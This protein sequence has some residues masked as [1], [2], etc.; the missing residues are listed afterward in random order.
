MMYGPD[1][2]SVVQSLLNQALHDFFAPIFISKKIPS[3]EDQREFLRTVS[4]I[5]NR[6]NDPRALSLDQIINIEGQEFTAKNLSES[7]SLLAIDEGLTSL[8]ERFN[9]RYGTRV[10]SRQLPTFFKQVD[11]D[12]I[13]DNTTTYHISKKLEGRGQAGL[14]NFYSD[15][16]HEVLIKEDDPDTCVL[17]GTASFVNQ[18]HLL[19]K[20]LEDC[21]NFASVGV[22]AKAQG[23]PMVVSIQD[24]VM[25]SDQSGRVRP[26]DEI[27]YG[28]KRNPNTLSSYESWYPDNIKQSIASLSPNVQWQLAASL[29]SC[30]IAGDESLHVGQFMAILDKDNNIT[31]IKRIDLGARERY[32]VARAQTGQHDPF[33]D[34]TQ[35]QA[36]G[37]WGKDYLTYLLADPSFRKIY[38]NLWMNLASQDETELKMKVKAAS[39]TAFLT[40]FANIPE[41]LREKT[42]QDV[43]A[44]FNKDAKSSNMALSGHTTED[45]ITSLA[46]QISDIDANRMIEMLTKV[47][48]EFALESQRDVQRFLV[49]TDPMLLKKLHEAS[50]LK[51]ALIYG[52]DKEARFEDVLEIIK[53]F[54]TNINELISS[55]SE[56]NKFRFQ[57]LQVL[58]ESSVDLL[59]A[60]YLQL[61]NQTHDKNQ[62]VE[63]LKALEEMIN[64]YQTIA[65]LSNYCLKTRSTDK[66]P[67]ILKAM[68]MTMKGKDA[69]AEY[70]TNK[71]FINLITTHTSKVSYAK[72]YIVSNQAQGE[73]LLRKIF[74]RHQ[75]DEAAIALSKNARELLRSIAGNRWDDVEMVT[76]DSNFNVYDALTADETGMTA[77]H[78]LMASE[79]LDEHG[80]NAIVNILTKSL[81]RIGYT[82][83]VLD[84]PNRDGKTPLDLLMQN[85]N[86]KVIIDKVNDSHIGASALSSAYRM[87]D[88]FSIKKY[89]VKLQ[90]NLDKLSSPPQPKKGWGLWS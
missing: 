76:K 5:I 67:Y 62:N 33:H 72:S 18:C 45:R 78:Y 70:I 36:H 14:A 11:E 64:K 56:S 1:E 90:E 2:P 43:L 12:L 58:S 22:I 15:G 85:K 3:F 32:A 74:K 49:M 65:D 13:G 51:Q 87:Q 73:I 38:M 39:K 27:V 68:E 7:L 20:T 63:Q 66:I 54:D 17:E 53:V 44:V 9:L 75:I 6:C 52:K 37:Q 30:A 83:A 10:V 60:L 79:V 55:S 89:D 59:Q 23:Q 29:F 86:A 41:S 50:E 28:V 31:G 25:P 84:L 26:W 57:Q 47:K 24:R 19:P 16:Q 40:Q 69:L 8:K 4:L 88:F 42:L 48:H 46:D 80:M 81:G 21:V 71:N 34:S 61:L 77:L 35:Y 82:N